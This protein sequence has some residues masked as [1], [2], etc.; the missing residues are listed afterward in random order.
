MPYTAFQAIKLLKNRHRFSKKLPAK[1]I[2]AGDTRHMPITSL[3]ESRLPGVD[4]L[5]DNLRQHP[6]VFHNLLQNIH[7]I[8]YFLIN[9]FL[10][11]E[12]QDVL[13]CDPVHCCLNILKVHF[14]G[15]VFCFYLNVNHLI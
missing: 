10:P 2:V 5:E 7:G 8:F 1:K 4:F 13:F 14:I 9:T 15:T 6:K 12:L 11:M 3:V